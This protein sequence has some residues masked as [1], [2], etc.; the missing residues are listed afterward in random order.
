M[1]AR[2][3]VTRAI[4]FRRPPRLPINGHGELS[5][6]TWVGYDMIQPQRAIGYPGM[7]QWTCWWDRSEVQNMGQVKGHPLEDVSR[8]K[9]FPWP[10]GDDARRYVSTWKWLDELCWPAKRDKYV[11][12]GIF[13]ILWERMH[14]L[15]GFE[16]C[17]M[18]LMDDTPEIHELAER[19]LEY[20]IQIVRNMH[21]I[22]GSSVQGFSFS[23]D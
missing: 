12:A 4:E 20:D 10:D 7:D 5:D 9:R 22:C 19:I 16:N 13:M 17:M 18:D 11:I 1:T 23:E 15:H 14:T 3:V 2:E 8:M 21:R 6:I